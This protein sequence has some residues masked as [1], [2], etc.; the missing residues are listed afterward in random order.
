MLRKIS[1]GLHFHLGE[2]QLAVPQMAVNKMEG[3]HLAEFYN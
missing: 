3:F 2:S 1:G